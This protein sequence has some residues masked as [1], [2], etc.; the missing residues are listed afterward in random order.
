MGT[1]Y[2]SRHRGTRRRSSDPPDRG[3]ARRRRRERRRW[4]GDERAE[5]TMREIRYL[6]ELVDEL[7]RGRSM[8]KILRT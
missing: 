3:G 6:D 7:A 1:R 2:A 4:H 8:E 5:P